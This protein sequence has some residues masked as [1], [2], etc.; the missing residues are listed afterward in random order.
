MSFFDNWSVTSFEEQAEKDGEDLEEGFKPLPDGVYEVEVDRAE[1]KQTAKKNGSGLSLGFKVTE[2]KYKGRMLFT[3][4]NLTN[5]NEKAQLIG[6]K[7][8]RRFF[9]ALSVDTL[10]PN[11]MIGR[12]LSVRTKIGKNAQDE[13]DT[14]IKGYL[15]PGGATQE[16]AKAGKPA[17]A[18]K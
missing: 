4:I 17:W 8:L 2:G 9:K 10:L 7:E 11:Q 12:K 1:E 13:P 16:Q 5:T 3:W 18:K 14:K 15:P 6:Q